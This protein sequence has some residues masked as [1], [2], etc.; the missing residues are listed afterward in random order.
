MQNIQIAGYLSRDAETRTTQQGDEVATWNVPVKQGWGDKE[1][2]NWFRVSVWG[3]RASFAAKLR[4]GD[5]VAVTGDLT[6]GEYNG[7]A[8]YEIRA[9]DFQTV[10][11]NKGEEHGRQHTDGSR[12]GGQPL[13]T[14]R[15]MA[16]AD[17]LDDRIP[18]LTRESIW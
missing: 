15:Q 7:K 18:F 6:I 2:T 16:P 17:D 9:A 4:K 3:K 13:N 1:Q 10:N 11:M 5:F 14:S 12:S 8:Q